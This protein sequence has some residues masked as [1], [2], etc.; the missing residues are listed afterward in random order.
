MKSTLNTAVKLFLLVV[1]IAY[2]QNSYA[3][4]HVLGIQTGAFGHGRNL[5]ELSFTGGVFYDYKINQRFGINLATL[6]RRRVGEGYSYAAYSEGR[7]DPLGPIRGSLSPGT[8][9]T[10]LC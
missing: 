9:I 8:E 7:P 10:S 4:T 2:T 1:L 3:Q 6:Y 5:K